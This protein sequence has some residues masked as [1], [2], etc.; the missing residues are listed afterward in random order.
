MRNSYQTKI[1]FRAVFLV[2]G[3][4]ALIFCCNE[5]VSAAPCPTVSAVVCSKAG[6]PTETTATDCDNDGYGVCTTGFTCVSG[7]CNDCD[8]TAPARFPGN[9][10]VCDSLDNDCDGSIDEGVKT[11]YYRDQ[12][13][14]TFGNPSVTTQACSVPTGYVTNNT[15]CD[16]SNAAK[17]PGN[18][19]ICDSLDNDC[20]GSIDEGVQTTYY[21]DQ[22][23]DTFGNPSV[24]TQACTAPA[25]FVA[26]NTDCDD[27]SNAKYPGNTEVCDQLDNDCD[28]T[29]NDGLD[30]SQ[31]Y[32]DDDCTVDNQ[33]GSEQKPFCSIQN[34]IDSDGAV[35]GTRIIVEAGTYDGFVVY[36][37]GLNIAAAAGVQPVIKG[38]K[39]T[40]A[41]VDPD[42]S[43]GQV[44]SSIVI[45]AS[46]ITIDSG[47]ALKTAFSGK[48]YYGLNEVKHI[49]ITNNII[50]GFMPISSTGD[51]ADRGYGIF[52]FG[53]NVLI[54]GVPPLP[55]RNTQDIYIGGEDAGNEII[56][57]N[58]GVG[59]LGDVPRLEITYNDLSE[60]GSILIIPGHASGHYYPSTV[61]ADIRRNWWG[62]ANGPGSSSSTPGVYVHDSRLPDILANGDG[63]KI[64]VINPLVPGSEKIWFYP[65]AE[66]DS[67]TSFARTGEDPDGDGIDSAFDNCPTIPNPDQSDNDSD[68][69][70]DVCD[71]CKKDPGNDADADGICGDID[72]CPAIGNSA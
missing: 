70:G 6:S 7:K 34:A 32:V 39:A 61:E 9:T 12:D 67:F 21:R 28:G 44:Y 27:T 59:I 22:D 58:R 10:E 19:E 25:G 46:Y 4:L 23:A 69:R 49:T 38:T 55:D 47:G 63:G 66:N 43:S 31:L 50:S 60:N 26:D 11:T 36:K 65:Y 71:P 72:N 15:D 35:S 16:D 17:Y 37:S 40:Q 62:A 45:L 68:G 14:D 13:T 1:V 54:P 5:S 2:F 18:T 24:T 57:N 30:C 51:R 48:N 29:I 52:I 53:S 42:S 56:N 20:D 8:D 64:F 3:I 41:I 33:T